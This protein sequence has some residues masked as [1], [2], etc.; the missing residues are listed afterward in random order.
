MCGYNHC[1]H[2][3]EKVTE[4]DSIMVGKRRLHIDCAEVRDHIEIIKNLYFNYVESANY[5]EVVGVINNIIFKKGVNPRYM[6]FALKHIIS[7]NVVIKSPYF[8][9]YLPKNKIIIKLW[10]KEN[11][12]N[13]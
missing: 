7:K 6:I 5:V 4:Q 11:G 13:K 2:K 1:L 12:V 8:L 9:H 3:G 10:E